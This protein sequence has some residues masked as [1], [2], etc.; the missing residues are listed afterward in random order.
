[1]CWGLKEHS[2]LKFSILIVA[3]VQLKFKIP[4]YLEILFV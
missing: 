2:Y 4:N 3:E 1:M